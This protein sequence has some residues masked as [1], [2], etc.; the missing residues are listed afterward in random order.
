[1][2][3]QNEKTEKVETFTKEEV[4]KM[5]ADAQAKAIEDAKAHIAKLNEENKNKRLSSKEI[6]EALGVQKEEGK[7]D[8]ELVKESLAN[9]NKTIEQ[10]QNDLKAKDDKLSLREK[11]IAA[12]KIAQK[13]NFIDI[14]D[15]MAKVDL[16]KDDIEEQIKNIAETKKH[17]IKTTNAGNSFT[18][19]GGE[20]PET[21]KEQH[22][23]AVA[24]GDIV[25]AIAL[26]LKMNK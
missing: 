25:S 5:V 11:Q 8:I 15:V 23:E 12:E 26:K 7:T 1:M 17:W 14:D 21:L 18:G 2:T 4:T 24:K 16:T 13:Y 9:Q 6:L 20:S 22:K 10:L 3:D 19:L